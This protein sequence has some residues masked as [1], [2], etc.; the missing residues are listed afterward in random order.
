MTRSLLRSVLQVLLRVSAIR[1][2]ALTL[3]YAGVLAISLGLAYQLRFDF[4][5]PDWLRPQLVSVCTIAVCVQLLCM[6]A[7]HQFD[8]LLSYFSTPDLKRLIF[9]CT[10]AVSA[11]GVLRLAF[12]IDLAP[13]RGVLLIH[14]FL[15]IV[16]LSSLRLIFRH[17]RLMAYAGSGRTRA[18]A[19]RLGIVGAGDCGAALAKELLTKPWLALQPVAFFDDYRDSLCSV[20][21]IPLVGRPERIAEFRSKLQLDEAIIAMPSAP[22]RRVRDVLKLIREAGLPCRIV[23]SLDQLA[24]GRVT[25]S[26][27]RPVAISDLL[28]RAP[29][30]IKGEAVREV[31]ANRTVMVTGA[32]GSIGSELCRQILSFGPAALVC[33]ERSEPQLYVIE[34]EL[35][36]QTRG[37]AFLPVVGDITRR[38]RMRELFRRFRPEV[39]FHAAAH[40]HV[41]MMELQPEEAIRNN[42]FGTALLADL[43]IEHGVERFIFISTDKAVNP[44]NV[45]GATKRLAEMYLQSLATRNVRTKFMAVRFGNV[46]GSSGSVVPTFERQIAAGGP[47]TVTHPEVTRFFMTIPEA[48]SLVLQSSAFGKGGDIFILEMGKP[49]RILDLAMQMIALS[50]LTPHE[51]IEIVFTGLRPGEKLY[52][53]LSHGGESVTATAHPKIVRFLSPPIHYSYV[54]AFVGELM[55][56][57]AGDEHDPAE[58][59][60]LLAK[61]LP[62]YTPFV[63]GPPRSA[64]APA[65]PVAFGGVLAAG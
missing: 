7:F 3:T 2:I 13:P 33:V 62:E 36:D 48:V 12:G 59:K 45:M 57:L 18:R 56:T 42:V 10:A 40:K 46:L 8:G 50:G 31:I 25:V 32:G 63:P 29:V 58:L 27:L 26:N 53:E 11:L 60:L 28:G 54:S 51:D 64:P 23:P 39:I 49:V 15:S 30:E 4:E 22:T 38:S 16:A 5:V 24:T 43:A 65:P 55:A 37:A 44:T 19:R 17:V 1:A 61:M 41:P 47:V 9:A 34:Q 14:Y 6:F 35:R 52:E 20:H 21:G